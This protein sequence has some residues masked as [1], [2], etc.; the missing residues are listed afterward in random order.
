MSVDVDA[1]VVGGGMAGLAAADRLA[2]RGLK[3]ML[4][5]ARGRTGGL[6]FG[7][8]VGGV[9]IDLGAESFAKRSRSLLDL[10]GELGLALVEPQ[11]RSW[12][13][14]AEHGAIRI[15]RGTLGI[16]TD[17]DDPEVVAALSS[18]G[19]RRA[20]EDLTMDGAVGADSPDL[21]TLVE[22]RLG[23]E[24]LDRLVSPIAGGI[25]SASPRRLS[26]DVVTPGLRERLAQEGSLVRASAAQRAAAPAGAVVASVDG[27][28]F[29]LPVALERRIAERGGEIWTRMV[30]TGIARDG[31]AWAV[32]VDNAERAT[33]PHLMGRASGR[34]A[35]V[36][37]NRLVVALDGRE[38][39]TLLRGIPELEIGDW[40]L[41]AGA[42]L[43]SVDL[44]VAN[45]ALD[46]A[47]RGSGLLVAPSASEDEAVKAKALTHY[48]IKW[49]WVLRDQ[50][51]HVLRVSY[52]RGPG[53]QVPT[54]SQA[55]RDAS[56][57]LGVE[58][59]FAQVRGQ[60]TIRFLN[61]LPPQTPDHRARVA[62]L[63]DAVAALPGLEVTGAWFA[64]TGLAAVLPHGAEAADRLAG[65]TVGA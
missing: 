9:A 48:S 43:A 63:A 60:R 12:V 32:T 27:G 42:D 3:P 39:L 19:L 64:G 35:T 55:L 65:T 5:E 24:V 17:L 14:S 41:P 16:P 56:T 61:S 26:P 44:A 7:G 13:W 25:H 62:R 34:P 37:T 33:E 40:E 45:P 51:L 50:P 49:P 31:D 53:T 21:A 8:D 6:V 4:L 22:T 47:P 23:R 59:T 28:L 57:L 30:V 1:L 52:G 46:A 18:D 29:R 54:L 11:G 38:A 15:P 36:R 20:R 10:C 2:Q 58:L